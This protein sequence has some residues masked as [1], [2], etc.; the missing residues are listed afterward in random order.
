MYSNKNIIFFDVD[1]TLVDEKTLEFPDSA[2][3][4]IEK[5]RANGHLAFVNTGRTACQLDPIKALMDFDGFVCGCGTYVEINNE[6]IFHKALDNEITQKLIKALVKYNLDAA[7]EGIDGVY[8]DH[9]E[10][11]VHPE[12][13]RTREI[14]LNENVCHSSF[15]DMNDISIDKLVLFIRENSD[16]DSFFEEFK[17]I[18]DFIKRSDDFYELIPL[19]HSK[20]TGIQ[21]LIDHLGIPFE[22]TYAIGDSSNDL[23]MLQYVKNS[24]AMGNS[25]PELFDLVTFV[26]KDIHDNGI[27]YALSHYNML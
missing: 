11:I 18:F 21:L 23:T 12:I 15:I 3:L 8:Y 6:P 20:A 9:I 27:E 10:N 19:N 7:L 16:F 2:R 14:H 26:T 1:G 17:D 22:N 4:A 13:L 24:I 25:S 5:A